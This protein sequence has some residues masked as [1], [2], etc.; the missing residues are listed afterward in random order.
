MRSDS[1]QRPLCLNILPERRQN[2][3]KTGMTGAACA[4]AKL[5]RPFSSMR[6]TLAQHAESIVI[7][8]P[9]RHS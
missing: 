6:F 5:R 8:G 2:C 9:L 7:N 4:R 1:K 3:R